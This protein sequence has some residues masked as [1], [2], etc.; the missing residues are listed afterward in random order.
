[1]SVTVIGCVNVDLLLAPLL[2]IPLPGTAAFVERMD[3]RVGGAGANAALA[4]LEAGMSP[5]LV[6]AVGD[7]HYGRWV[8]E[9]LGE[10]GL[11]DDIVVD[12]EQ[13]TG[14]TVAVEAPGRDRSFITY[15]GVT[16]TATAEIVPPSSLAVDHVLVCDY[17]CAPAMRGEPTARLLQT[18]RE[19][20]ART[21]FDTA[22]D[23]DGFAPTT[24]E[25]IHALLPLVDVFLP[26]EAEARALAG[27]DSVVKAGRDLQRRSGG[28]V[29]IKLGADGCVAFG[30]Q[31]G[32]LSSPAPVIE[33][34]DTT[35]A[36]DAFNAGLVSAFASGRGWPEALEAATGLA[37]SLLAR[38]SNDRHTVGKE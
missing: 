32:R 8:L 1:M 9:Q 27:T 33:P 4:L 24:R 11:A 35:G 18:A 10:F 13:A 30:P 21:Y 17:F 29:V 5:R 23:T 38:P 3:L 36:G 6:G 20:G 19:L 22:W 16:G 31:G 2:D 14:L 7:D 25:E 15:L 12:P 34:T 37:S 28:W 26:N